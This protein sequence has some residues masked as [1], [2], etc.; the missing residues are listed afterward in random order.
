M[1]YFK[2]QTYMYPKLASRVKQSANAIVASKA[3]VV[4]SE[5]IFN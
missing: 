4:I 1:P 5:G 2:F 3:G